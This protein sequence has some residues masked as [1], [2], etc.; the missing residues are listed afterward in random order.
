MYVAVCVSSLST[1]RERRAFA[2]LG[3]AVPLVKFLQNP[4]EPGVVESALA[5]FNL[6]VCKGNQ[7]YLC[8][9]ALPLL[10]NL[11]RNRRASDEVRSYVTDILYNLKSHPGNMTLIYKS[12]LRVKTN[13]AFGT[14][15]PNSKNV[16]LSFFQEQSP[17][18]LDKSTHKIKSEFS[19]WYDQIRS[20]GNFSE[21]PAR[22][23]TCRGPRTQHQKHKIQRNY[24]PRTAGHAGVRQKIRPPTRPMSPR[25]RP[26]SARA[27][28]SIKHELQHRMRQPTS[29]IWEP[30]LSK[31]VV[32]KLMKPTCVSLLQERARK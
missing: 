8:R 19:A 15:K 28:S 6:S 31:V 12:E 18:P 9:L 26:H 21:V 10:I 16:S 27:K 13:L 2:K 11:A 25:V 22:P 7:K 4:L 24:R 5:I 32:L 30:N 14:P 3:G 1:D 17:K 20:F 23:Q 29:R